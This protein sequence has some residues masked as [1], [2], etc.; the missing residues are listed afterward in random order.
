MTPT[1]FFDYCEAKVVDVFAR[2]G[3]WRDMAIVLT[4][5]DQVDFVQIG[6]M[7]TDDEAAGRLADLLERH[8][9]KA[10]V[11]GFEALALGEDGEI[12]PEEAGQALLDLA[13]NHPEWL[14]D[15][16]ADGDPDL[17]G[18]FLLILMAARSGERR[19]VTFP[20]QVKDGRKVLGQ[21]EEH[22]PEDDTTYGNLFQ[23]R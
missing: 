2:Q 11:V 12:D 5:D 10:Y 21:R 16:P 9:L 17:P 22:E 4:Q 15:V 23:S 7:G 18:H 3:G 6:D 20:I 13:E 19:V 1:R 8:H 14:R